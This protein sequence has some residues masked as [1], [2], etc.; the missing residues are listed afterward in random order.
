[1]QDKPGYPKILILEERFPC[2]S[3]VHKMG[4][5]VGDEIVLVNPSEVIP[6]MAAVPKGKI[7]T[8]REICLALAQKHNVQGCCTLT[9]G[10]FTMTIAN[11]VEEL[12]E[13]G[14]ESGLT[15]LPWWRTLKMDGFL[16]DK[17]P[18]GEVAQKMYLEKEG[19]SFFNR[20]KKI[21]VS[22]WHLHI[23]DPG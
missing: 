9:A 22:D 16:N 10:I 23:Y 15:G 8:L 17:Y 14:K 19:F 12:K 2:Y 5:N 21:Q 13:S 20:G 3:A 11:A 18:G 7:T 4:A 1:M 6:L